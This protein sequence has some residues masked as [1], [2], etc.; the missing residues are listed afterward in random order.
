MHV[1][2]GP[3]SSPRPSLWYSRI[4]TNL[5]VSTSTRT[6]AP[7][8][9]HHAPAAA[10]GDTA[11]SLAFAA[12]DG[13]VSS[14]PCGR[15]PPFGCPWRRIRSCSVWVCGAG[16]GAVGRL[17]ILQGTPCL[18]FP[19]P[20]PRLGLLDPLESQHGGA[21]QPLSR[22]HHRAGSPM[23]NGQGPGPAGKRGPAR[24]ACPEGPGPSGFVERAVTGYRRS[25]STPLCRATG[26]SGSPLCG[27]SRA[28]GRGCSR[29]WRPSS[30]RTTDYG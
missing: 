27:T 11:G 5:T 2:H 30:A 4:R 29:A 10:S 3:G 1:R 16:C 14:G 6:T 26:S 20:L 18:A 24:P 13:L 19:R 21:D 9:V 7:A 23:R 28:R 12:S 25:A 15:S 17:R 22:S 8:P